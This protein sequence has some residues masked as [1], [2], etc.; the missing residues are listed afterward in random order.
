MQ[1]FSTFSSLLRIMVTYELLT[2]QSQRLE[3]VCDA[4]PETFEEVVPSKPLEESV[5]SGPTPHPNKVPNLFVQQK[6][7]SM[8]PMACYTAVGG[9][10]LIGGC[11][12][13]CECAISLRNTSSSSRR[14]DYTL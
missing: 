3:L 10:W 1:A 4:Y 14:S 2:V 8:L 11:A 5:F 7:K 6:L 13:S 9:S 12:L